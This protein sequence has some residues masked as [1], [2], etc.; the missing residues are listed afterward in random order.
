MLRWF[1]CL[2][3]L[4]CAGLTTAGLSPSVAHAGSG[5]GPTGDFT[6]NDLSG[7]AVSL[8]DFRGKVVVISFWATWCQPCILELNTLKTFLPKYEDQGLVILAIDTDGP[9]T[10]PQA[11]SVAKRNG[12][13]M[14]VLLDQEGTVMS[15]LNPR[16]NTPY[17]V[18]IDRDG[19]V[20]Y[21]H[22]GFSTGD[23]PKIEER[24]KKMLAKPASGSAKKKGSA[25]NMHI[26]GKILGEAHADNRN[27][28]VDDDE[29]SLLLNR[30]NIVGS[31][32]NWSG[33]M[34]LEFWSFGEPASPD[35]KDE[36]RLERAFLQ[37]KAGNFTLAVGDF[38]RQ[39]GRGFALSLRKEAD[40]GVDVA[41][42]GGSISFTSKRQE[43]IVFGGYANTVNID[44]VSQK[45]VDD[46]QDIMA[47]LSYQLEV[48][49]GFR[50]G[51]HG[52]FLRAEEKLLA[53]LDDDDQSITGGATLELHLADEL[54]VLYGEGN[55]Q[56]RTLAGEDDTGIAGYLSLDVNAGPVALLFEGLYLDAFEQKGSTNTA[57]GS[58]F[59]YSR[60]PN[61]ERL[62][63]EVLNNRDV[64]G[65]RFR[66]EVFLLDRGFS[67]HLNTMF[68]QLTSTPEHPVYQ[69]H[70][71]GGVELQF[72]NGRSRVAV[73][74]G[75]RTER[76]DDFAASSEIKS[77]KH[78]EGDYLQTLSSSVSLHIVSNN[79]FRTLKGKPYERGSTFVGLERTGFGGITF[80]VGYDN[81]D[82]SEGT[83]NIFFAG[84]VTAELPHS[85][86]R[87]TAGTQRGG[88]KCIAGVCR[89]FPGFAGVRAE[90]TSSF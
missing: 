33:S 71:F 20:S 83:A 62:D 88:L 23:A 66:A 32:T 16:G 45:E 70:G 49:R 42:R 41:I 36:V 15:V 43:L 48:T 30:L 40:F 53:F 7:K 86:L 82:P 13:T 39:L 1:K 14:P 67:L 44:N 85:L 80:E 12:W 26:S 68:R 21:T 3:V 31:K 90:L 52:L 46:V 22:E 4:F 18:Y 19:V 47:G 74:G 2:V 55:M 89:E 29:Y 35:F 75:Y 69:V 65:G 57:L 84:I 51:T 50:V 59:D 87:F 72:Q 61:L 77:M 79:E 34:R 6:L 5:S 76:Q 24:I 64:I 38:H 11:R 9:E 17:S 73:S 10:L 60:G 63:Q 78:V 28:K 58:R 8:S 56:K 54:I 25:I 81:L 27:G 37:R